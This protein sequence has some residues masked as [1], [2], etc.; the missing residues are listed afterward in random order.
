MDI[1]HCLEQ[2]SVRTLSL[3]DCDRTLPDAMAVRLAVFPTATECSAVVK[4]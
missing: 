1:L 2:S 3:A 4:I